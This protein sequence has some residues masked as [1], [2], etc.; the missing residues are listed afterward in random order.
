M[1]GGRGREREGDTNSKA[2]SRLQA[3]ST[4]PETGL[5]LINYKIMT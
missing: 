4:E 3:D 2:G 5:E 1:S